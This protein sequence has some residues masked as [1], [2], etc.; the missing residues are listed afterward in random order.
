MEEQ[1]LFHIRIIFLILSSYLSPVLHYD[2]YEH[3]LPDMLRVIKLD[4]SICGN[5]TWTDFSHFGLLIFDGSKGG[6][7][8]KE[9][10]RVLNEC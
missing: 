5:K 9:Y 8:V 3:A 7:P 4:G 1:V 6:T 2:D 10:Y